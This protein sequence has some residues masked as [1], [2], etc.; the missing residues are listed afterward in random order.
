MKWWWFFGGTNAFY[1]I[2][3]KRH[4]DELL[5]YESE[6]IASLD[7]SWVQLRMSERRLASNDRDKDLEVRIYNFSSSGKHEIIGSVT[8]RLSQLHSGRKLDI[9]NK[10]KKNV[11]TLVVEKYQSKV[12]YQFGDFLEHGLQLALVNCIDFTA[13]NGIASDKKSLHYT[14]SGKSLYEKALQSVTNILL[15]YD[16]DKLVPCYGFGSKLKHPKLDTYGKV[17]HCFPLNFNTANPDLYKL[18][19]ILKAYRNSIPYLQFSGPTKFGQL[20]RQAIEQCRQFKRLGTHYMILFI[21]TDGEIHDRQ[22]VIDLLIECNYLPISVIIVG[23]GGGEFQIMHELD[24][25]NMQ[26]VDSKGNKT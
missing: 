19:E 25:D 21:L 22:E 6:S 2:F 9:V 14:G 12:Q 8:F 15:D 24:D 17:N 11:G 7:P 1:R 4:K 3:R 13:S 18:D 20:F 16:Y 26:M 23:I 10:D 5:V